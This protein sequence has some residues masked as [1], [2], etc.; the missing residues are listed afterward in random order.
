VRE[1][2]EDITRRLFTQ[3]E[4]TAI[5]DEFYKRADLPR[6]PVESVDTVE[7]YDQE[8]DTWKA[9]DASGYDVRGRRFELDGRN[10]GQPLRITYTCGYPE[11]PAGLKQQLLRD[12]RYNYDHRDPG[13]SGSARVQDQSAY[14]K[15][16]PY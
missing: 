10:D 9:V 14:R 8:A 16:R 13:H 4:A 11:L 6:P 15:Y 1:E 7:Y 5:W 2:A 12:I 3:R